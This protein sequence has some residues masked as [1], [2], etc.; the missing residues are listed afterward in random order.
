MG[1]SIKIAIVGDYNFTYN[2]HHATNL[3]IDHSAHFL[4]IEASY[5]WIKLNEFDLMCI[6]SSHSEMQIDFNE[7]RG[8]TYGLKIFMKS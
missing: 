7:I 1:Q 5:Y 3:A 8:M 2:S 4:E 6:V